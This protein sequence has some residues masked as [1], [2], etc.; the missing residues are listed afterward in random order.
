MGPEYL[1]LGLEAGVGAELIGGIPQALFERCG[2]GAFFG[3][4]NPLH[5]QSAL[6]IRRNA[7]LAS[8]IFLVIAHS[9]CFSYSAIQPF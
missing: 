7:R 6:H 8:R 3:R 5:R 9:R 4:G 2:G 1:F